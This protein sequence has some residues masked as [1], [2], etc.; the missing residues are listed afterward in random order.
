VSAE[1]P[2][3]DL[4]RI[5]W[6]VE[7]P[8][9]VIAPGFQGVLDQQRAGCCSVH[10]IGD[11]YRM[12]Y[13][14]TDADGYH[15]ILAAESPAVNPNAWKPLGVVLTRQADKRHKNV[16]PSFAHIVSRQDGPWLMYVCAHG[17]GGYPE[18]W[19]TYLA[20]SHDQGSTW[21]Y[22]GDESV[23]PH[24]RS[25]NSK[26]TGSVCVIR[27]IGKWRMYYTSFREQ[28]LDWVGIGYAESDDG[29]HWTYPV[30]HLVVEPRGDAVAPREILCSKPCVLKENSRYRM[31]VG[32]I[33]SEY[34]LRSL[35]SADGIHWNG[36]TDGRYYED[37]RLLGGVG[38]SGAFDD[39]KRSYA[40]VVRDGD[41]YLL[42]YTGNEYGMAGMGFARGR[43]A[44]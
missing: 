21:Q 27:E 29:I 13:W 44:R 28:G 31:W 43:S 11:T 30:D 17:E 41:E 33:G 25:W 2:A 18:C 35:T 4:P 14:A 38:P 9:P 36:E 3:V 7:K 12:Y 42:W 32:T 10:R 5:E 20:V 19:S 24:T 22:E 26:A 40:S 15:S 8:K 1:V 39:H 23:L 34:R 16:G 37:G 6:T